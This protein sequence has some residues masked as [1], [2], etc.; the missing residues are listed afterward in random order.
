MPACL[1]KDHY[2][3]FVRSD[4]FRKLVEKSLHGWRIGIG[5]D[6][7]EGIVRARLHGREDG[8]EGKTLIAEPRRPLPPLP[9]DVADTAF[10]A[11]PRLILEKQAYALVF[12]RTLNVF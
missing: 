11:N 2:R 9:P 1:I 4:R 5:H 7:S 3:M 8:G 10:L 6:E 12:M